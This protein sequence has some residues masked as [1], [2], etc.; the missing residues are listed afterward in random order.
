MQVSYSSRQNFVGCPIVESVESSQT[1]E[2]TKNI[3]KEKNDDALS[4]AKMK[5]SA[6]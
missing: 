2:Q 3:S 4:V 6:S 5:I 1:I